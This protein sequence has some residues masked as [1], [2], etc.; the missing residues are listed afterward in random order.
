MYVCV[1]VCV[2]VYVCVCVCVLACVRVYM[3]VCICG[4]LAREPL[5]A[6]SECVVGVYEGIHHTSLTCHEDNGIIRKLESPRPS[7]SFL[8][9]ALC[10]ASWLRGERAPVVGGCRQLPGG[11]GVDY[12]GIEK[13]LIPPP[14]PPPPPTL[15]LT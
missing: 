11:I 1:C 4:L 7:P 12:V 13:P 3:C 8:P 15:L 5:R 2:C 10:K 9:F 14:P 6:A